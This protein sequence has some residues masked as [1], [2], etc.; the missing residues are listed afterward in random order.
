MDSKTPYLA[1]CIASLPSD[2]APKVQA[3]CLSN[4]T[5]IVLDT[6]IRF[7]SG[8]ECSVD[9]SSDTIQEWSA[10][11]RVAKESLN[12]LIQAVPNG[13]KRQREQDELD[14]HN[15]KRQKV[16]SPEPQPADDPPVFTLHSISTTSPIRKKSDITIHRSSIKFTN[17]STQL[18]DANI[19]LSSITRAFIVPTR[20]KQKAHWTVVLLTSDMPDRG[21]ASNANSNGNIQIIFGVDAVATTNTKTTLYE[22]PT[23]VPTV[24]SKGS[25]T[26]SMLRTF[27]SH[28]PPHALPV[29]EPS[30][31][32]FRSAVGSG[33]NGGIPGI[34][35][36][37]AAKPGN[38]WF[39]RE[40]ILWG[41]GKPCEFWA[42]EDLLGKNEGVRLVSATGRNCSVFLTRKILSED[43][44]SGEDDEEGIETEFAMV[45]GKE[46]PGINQWVRQHRH[47]FGKKVTSLEDKKEV[48]VEKGNG[49]GKGK[50]KATIVPSGPITINQLADDSDDEDSDFKSDSED[51]DGSS[52]TDDSS[53]EDQGG[54]EG[55]AE[56]SGAEEDDDDEEKEEELLE[57]NHPLMRPGAM[58]RMS[59]AAMNMVVGMMEDNVAGAL[60][61]GE[62][63]EDEADSDEE[64]EEDT[65]LEPPQRIGEG[66]SD[67]EDELDD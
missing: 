6:L 51:L 25:E 57:R 1:R 41:E 26:I 36:Y 63:P 47:L 20:G 67:E 29:L 48:E 38:L 32:V 2:F 31:D 40:G 9:A 7:I 34:E 37:L 12:D 3:L 42:V 28:L 66:D 43:N 24:I 11:Q 27:I 35:A 21:K 13:N 64:V 44:A 46:Q 60:G 5:E 39:M 56:A 55:A 53:D 15:T 54:D 17:P 58:P 50:E 8:A 45:D 4:S 59:K 65:M 18:V 62:E 61:G 49:K 33:S 19:P 23:A 14:E 16:P 52:S 22:G 10:K 30:T